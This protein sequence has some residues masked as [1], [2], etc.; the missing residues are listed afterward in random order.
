VV[1]R[2]STFNLIYEN[3]GACANNSGITVYKLDDLGIPFNVNYGGQ[4]EFVF[5]T[6]S[7]GATAP[8]AMTF[9]NTGS[10]TD[11]SLHVFGNLDN[12][13]AGN[14]YFV[15]SYFNGFEGCNSPLNIFA[16]DNGSSPTTNNLTDLQGSSLVGCPFFNITSANLA[17]YNSICG[18]YPSVIG[19]SNN[20]AIATGFKTGSNHTSLSSVIPNPTNE[21]ITFSCNLTEKAN[22]KL[23]LYNCFGQLVKKIDN[24]SELNSGIY[25]LEINFNNLNVP[26][27]VYFLKTYDNEKIS[28]YKIIYDKD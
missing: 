22:L 12:T 23:E 13:S 25:Q 8:V 21:K 24:V 17:S 6:G 19:G 27:G 3:Y 15:E 16:Y 4:D 26:Y 18:P 1:E 14:H 20:K 9:N 10:A 2:L 28:S 5:N 11:E 7:T